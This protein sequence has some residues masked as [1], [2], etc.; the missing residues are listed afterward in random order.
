L[1]ADVE[2]SLETQQR[3]KAEARA[4]ERRLKELERLEAQEA[5]EKLERER[6]AEQEA[7]ER[8]ELMK[9][10]CPATALRHML[11]TSYFLWW[12]GSPRTL[13]ESNHVSI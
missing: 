3:L 12:F 5:A 10:H 2:T 13:S 11:A 1:E 6:Q 4:A 9:V 7:A 8:A